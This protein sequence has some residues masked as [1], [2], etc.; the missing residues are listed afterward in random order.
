MG[1]IQDGEWALRDCWEKEFSAALEL[2]VAHE[3]ASLF[4]HKSLK[5]G[6]H[7]SLDYRPRTMITGLRHK[8]RGWH[9][10]LWY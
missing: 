9:L 10:K 4:D 6:I 7:Y 5:L 3:H 2:Q 8:T 1:K